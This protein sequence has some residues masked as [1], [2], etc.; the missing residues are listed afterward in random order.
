MSDEIEDL[1]QSYEELKKSYN[2]KTKSIKLFTEALS[3]F[4]GTEISI[5]IAEEIL[6]SMD[7]NQINKITDKITL[8]SALCDFGNLLIKEA[9]SNIEKNYSTDVSKK[10]ENKF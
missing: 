5:T 8:C 6:N 7:V 3:D 1:R 4:I 9:K 10:Y 2:L